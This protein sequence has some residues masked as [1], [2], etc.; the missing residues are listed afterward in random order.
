MTNQQ[1]T[2]DRSRNGDRF[3]PAVD[4]RTFIAA[5]SGVGA[6]MLAGCT[7]DRSPAAESD[8]GTDGADSADDAGDANAAGSNFRLLISD[9]PADIGDFDR[10]D[11]TFDKARIFDGGNEGEDET[12]ES[13]QTDDERADGEER[14]DAEEQSTD[15]DSAEDGANADGNENES[16]GG[17]TEETTDETE[18][19]DE[20][21]DPADGVERKRG[22]YILDLDGATV[23]LTQVVGDKASGVF[24]GELSDGRY[25]KIE[26]HVADVEGIVDGDA[27]DVNVPSEKLQLTNPFEI[28]AGEPI[29]FVFDINVVKRGKNNG[30][31]LKPVISK[32]G[33]NGADVDV[34]EVAEDGEDG[35]E[36][37]TKGS[38][39]ED[40]ESDGDE[41]TIDGAEGDKDGTDSEKNGEAAD[42][43][44]GDSDASNGEN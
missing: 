6:T 38:K 26:L 36:D 41:D 11:V 32:S 12:D 2:R 17:G 27:V 30:Y 4:R 35:A 8:D 34:D 29:E 13:E 15:G 9:M 20:T 24:E 43:V 19:A 1:S 39:D 3:G 10:L 25:R 22:F 31:N 14:A 33:I 28:R 18:D 44:G 21:D 5:G 23:D 16:E 37:E 40:D 42:E 7:S